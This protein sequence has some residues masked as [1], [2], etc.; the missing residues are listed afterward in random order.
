MKILILNRDYPRFLADM[1]ASKP[2]LADA[3]YADQLAARNVTL[4]GV[5]DFYSRGFIACGHQAQEIHV[6]NPW[7]QAAWAREHGLRTAMP[8]PAA[9]RK[10]GTGS[11][12]SRVKG[13]ARRSLF[14]IARRFLPRQL[15]W[16]E[17]RVLAA[18]IEEIAPT[19]LLNQEMS[20]IRSRCLERIT[21]KTIKVVGQIASA[22]PMGESYRRYD[23]I[24]SSLPNMV[25]YF[26]SRGARSE[27]SRLAFD[28]RVLAKVGAP[29]ERDIDVSFVGSLSADHGDRIRLIEA[30]AEQV[31]LQVWGSGVD[32]L[33]KSSPIRACHRGE[34]WGERMYRILCRSRIT[35]NQHIDLAEGYSNNM[36]LYEATGC[37]ALMIVDRGRNLGELFDPSTEVVPYSSTAECVEAVRG[38]LT[39]E[40][41]RARIAAA[42]QRRTL[43]EH[44]YSRRTEELSRLLSDL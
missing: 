34:A 39:D 6:N 13:A 15:R 24:V 29:L 35:I 40:E 25:H 22:L 11:L 10:S 23:L 19:V 27:T 37:G 21:P 26:K 28:P 20:Y 8:R 44:T 43:A 41:S 31:P 12:L 30:L 2:E 33:P 7:L 16:A 18:Q 36:R 42:G 32:E 3:S 1:Y 17:E 5:A 9:P 4:F 38:M 14:P